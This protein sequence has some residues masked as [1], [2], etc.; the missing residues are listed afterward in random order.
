MKPSGLHRC[1]HAAMWVT[2]T[3]VTYAD[4]VIPEGYVILL[5]LK[6][7][8]KLLR[9]RNN[10]AKVVDGMTLSFGD[11]ENSGDEARIK[12][13]RLPASDRVSTDE[14]VFGDDGTP[15]NR[16]TSGPRPFSLH[17]S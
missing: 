9:G 13:N 1:Q 7:D 6:A 12:E 17:V 16:T 11:A 2:W 14:W 4:T 3:K 15:T 10:F 8:M 5:P